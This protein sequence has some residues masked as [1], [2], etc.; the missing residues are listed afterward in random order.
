MERRKN[1]FMEP[2][3]N[4]KVSL[5][6]QRNV[7]SKCI[8]LAFHM[9]GRINKRFY[10]AKLISYM[11][12]SGVSSWLHKNL[13]LERQIFSKIE[14]YLG[15]DVDPSLFYI[16]GFLNDSFDFSLA[17]ESI[18]KNLDFLSSNLIEDAELVKII[19]K[20]EA[21]LLFSR[22]DNTYKALDLAFGELLNNVNLINEEVS[23]FDSVSVDGSAVVEDF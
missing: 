4:E 13:V 3:K 16:K 20:N 1:Y 19:K 17:E 10:V 11:L 2:K 21:S 12:S 6:I 18:F 8:V 7:P 15:E 22:I 5:K 14:T 23:I 9:S